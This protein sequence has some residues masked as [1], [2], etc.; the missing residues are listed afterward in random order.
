MEE[1]KNIGYRIT[2]SIHIG[3]TEYVIGVHEKDPN[4]F[5]T[6]ACTDGSNYFWGHYLTSREDAERDLVK[7]AGE[8]LRF[9]DNLKK[10]QNRK[11][12]YQR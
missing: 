6:W 1:R 8:Q 11:S 9:L 7:R 4:R 5:V 2:D 3:D 12:E 10:P